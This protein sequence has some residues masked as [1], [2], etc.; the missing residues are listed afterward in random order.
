MAE[1]EQPDAAADESRALAGAEEAAAREAEAEAARAETA[2]SAGPK[3]VEP[4]AKT[5]RKSTTPATKTAPITVIEPSS[6][7]GDRI[8]RLESVS[9]R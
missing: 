4:K 8:T 6:A 2:K 1:S 3:V 5:S 7:P 9:V